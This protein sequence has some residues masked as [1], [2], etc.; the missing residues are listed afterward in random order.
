MKNVV[1]VIFSNFY[2]VTFP[3]FQTK[4]HYRCSITSRVLE[5]VAFLEGADCQKVSMF[6]IFSQNRVIFPG[7]GIEVLKSKFP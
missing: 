5:V 4:L 2:I 7:F 6:F 3:A 1:G